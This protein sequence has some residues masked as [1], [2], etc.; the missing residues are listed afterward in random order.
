MASSAIGG[1]N[2]PPQRPKAHISACAL[3]RSPTGSQADSMRVRLGKQPASPV[4]NMKRITSSEPRF[5]AAPV[6]AVNSDHS[7]TTWVR[8]RRTPSLSPIRPMGISIRA[9]EAA[10]TL[11]T[12]PISVLVRLNSLVMYGA[13][14]EIATRWMYMI[15][16]SASANTTTQ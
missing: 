4:P 7:N 16:A 15:M 14:A 11:K 12:Q 13:A 10:N 2:A 3:M 1:A 6:N 5:Q 8:M 9:Y